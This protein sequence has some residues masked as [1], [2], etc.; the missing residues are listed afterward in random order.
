MRTNVLTRY[1]RHQH[2]AASSRATSGY[3]GSG[4]KMALS[5]VCRFTKI[6]CSAWDSR[7][8][9]RV[10]SHCVEVLPKP[11]VDCLVPALWT[12][13]AAISH[14]HVSL[15]SAVSRSSTV[16]VWMTCVRLLRA[17]V[18]EVPHV[19]MTHVNVNLSHSDWARLRNQPDCHTS[20]PSA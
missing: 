12:H 6:S 2:K 4:V 17:R 1:P 5:S 13:A 16:S 9:S 14:S 3:Q 19:L 11:R 20:V 7:R 18:R 15:S 10:H 8:W